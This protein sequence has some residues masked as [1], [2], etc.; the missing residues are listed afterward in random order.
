M[1]VL[2]GEKVTR[3]WSGDKYVFKRIAK[4]EWECIYQDHAIIPQQIIEDLG[5]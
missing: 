2:I 4:G 1:S 5:D 3:W